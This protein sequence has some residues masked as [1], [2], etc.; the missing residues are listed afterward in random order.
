MGKLA[1]KVAIVTGASQGL[2]RGI[3]QAFAREGAQVVVAARSVE[4]LRLLPDSV[5]ADSGGS[6][7]VVPTDVTD[8]AQ[9]QNLF[10][11]TMQTFG[12][13][14]ILVNN[15]AFLGGAPLDELTTEMWNHAVA[16]NLTAPFLC[17][18]AAL[19]IMKQQQSGRIINVASI[20]AQRVRP[21]SAPYSA[22]KHALWGLTQ[23]TALE[24]REHGIVCS[25]IYPGN[26]RTESRSVPDSDFNRE[27][28]MSV[29]EVAEA[30]LF[31]A[32]QPPHVNLLELTL[33]PTEQA[34]IGR[35]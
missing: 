23:V 24:G 35:G 20:S 7:L 5:S 26:I 27:P 12:R 22:T 1:N 4:R 11:Q 9:V 18:R 28:M 33:L 2:G 16:V 3:A 29:E 32:S 34:F 15:A 14:D 21:N 17:T 6:M 30:V 13:L 31:M 10:A 19:R 8:E 25:C